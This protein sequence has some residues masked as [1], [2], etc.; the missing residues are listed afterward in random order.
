M[1]SV[2]PGVL[3]SES[4]QVLKP[5]ISVIVPTYNR[6]DSLQRLMDSL[7]QQ[8]ISPNV[9]EVIVVD[10]GSKKTSHDLLNGKY[11][12]SLQWISQEN[13]GA[14]TSRNNGASLSQGE[15]LV[16]IDDD[17]TVSESTLQALVNVCLSESKVIALGMPYP[18]SIDSGSTFS[19]IAVSVEA[20]Y[21]TK[22]ITLNGVARPEECNTQILAVRRTDFFNLG[23]FQDPT[24]GW[25]N[26]DDVDFG[27]RAHQAGYRMMRV[28]DA[29]GNHWD[30][31]LSTLNS[32]TQRWYRASA[33]AV[34]LFQRYPELIDHITMFADMIPIDW[35]N[36][37][38]RKILRKLIRKL[39]SNKM[40]LSAQSMLLN[41]LE[42][43]YP[44]EPIMERLYQLITGGYK[45]RGFRQGLQQYGPLPKKMMSIAINNDVGEGLSN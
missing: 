28:A 25:P 45:Y 34:R 22:Y 13:Q 9:F 2:L 41:L 33:S 23:M 16:F 26:W 4:E 39:S 36:D 11:P 6:S 37:P 5:A 20:G 19:R 43:Y 21:F 14:T 8:L 30:H 44:S 31:S 18:F 17:I 24:G 40:V 42:K 12:F 38:P 35:H 3:M 29:V 27:Y 32:A 10:D 7:S 1:F 15:I